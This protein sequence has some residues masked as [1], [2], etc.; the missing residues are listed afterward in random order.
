MS[1]PRA[2]SSSRLSRGGGS[3]IVPGSVARAQAMAGMQAAAQAAQAS[4]FRQLATAAKRLAAGDA[5]YEKGD[6]RLATAIYLRLSAFRPPNAGTV[7][8]KERLAKL[9]ADARTKMQAIDETIDGP[10]STSGMSENTPAVA[11][12]DAATVLKAFEDYLRL[13]SLYGNVP[14]VK[15]EIHAQIARQRARPQYAAVLN[16]GKAKEWWDLAQKHEKDDQLCCAY[17]AYQEAKK[18]APAPS[19]LKAQE[20]FDEL[21]NDPEIVKSAEL[22]KELRWCHQ[23]FHRASLLASVNPDRAKEIFGEIVSRAPEDTEIHRAAKAEFDS[24]R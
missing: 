21:K 24:R 18:L 4:L 22:C 8:A 9:A 7:A 12:P 23:A 20:R 5:A 6:I 11:T 2:G 1:V 19:A 16:E 17:W 10:L 15:K 13:E 3:S 14:A